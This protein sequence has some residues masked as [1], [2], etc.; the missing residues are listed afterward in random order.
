M[1]RCTYHGRSTFKTYVWT[2]FREDL[3]KIF[4]FVVVLKYVHTCTCTS[5]LVQ[6]QVPGTVLYLT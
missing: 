1:N 5:V 6:R 2:L 3:R 4:Y